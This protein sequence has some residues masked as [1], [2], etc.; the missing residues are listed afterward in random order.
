[1]KTIIHLLVACALALSATAASAQVV[2]HSR[3]TGLDITGLE[4]GLEGSTVATRGDVLRWLFVAHE[5]IGLSELRPAANAQIR[6]VTSMAPTDAGLEVTTDAFGRAALEL[7]IPADAPANFMVSLEMNGREHVRRRFDLGVTTVAPQNL[8]VTM[9]RASVP[10]GGTLRAWGRL[11]HAVTSRPYANSEIELEWRNATGAP[12]AAPVHLRTDGAGVFTSSIRAPRSLRG[13]VSVSAH[14]VGV[15]NA[16]IRASAQAEVVEATTNAQLLIALSP[17]TLVV[18][19]RN[20][21]RIVAIVRSAEGRPIRN[22]IV[23]GNWREPGDVAARARTDMFGRAELPFHSPDI[24]GAFSDA[25]LQV[26]A[27]KPGFAPGQSAVVV[28]VAQASYA[29]SIAVEAGHLPEA[30]GGNVWIRVVNIDGSAAPAGVPV[31][32]TGPRLPENGVAGVTDASGIATVEINLLPHR[33]ENEDSCGGIAST[34]ISTH[35]GEGARVVRSDHCMP[36]DPDA[37]L[38]M[39]LGAAMATPAQHIRID[40]ARA[41]S[42]RGMPVV[43]TAS[44]QSSANAGSGMRALA[45]VIVPGSASVGELALPA[46]AVGLVLVR[47]RALIGNERVEVRGGMAALWVT[48]AARV[49]AQTSLDTARGQIT[50]GFTGATEADRSVYA[51]ALPIDEARSLYSTQLA[52]LASFGMLSDSRMDVGRAEDSFLRGA[53]AS[54]VPLDVDA[55]ALLRGGVVIPVPAPANPQALGHLRDPWRARAR[56]VGG[57]LALLFHAIESV[58]ANAVPGNIENVALN[59]PRGWEFNERIMDAVDADAELGDG[60]ATALGGDT[61]DIDA[62]RRMDSSFTYD[63]VARRITRVRL[64][65]LLRDLRTFVQEHQLDLRWG[66]RGD[67]TEWLRQATE[68]PSKL[69]DA[70]GR[71]FALR[72][73]PGGRARFSLLVPVS[74]YELVSSGPNGRFG[75]ADDVWDPTGRVLSDTSLYGSAVGESALVAR[76]RGVEL[77]RA[78]VSMMQEAFDGDLIVEGGD[79]EEEDDTDTSNQADWDALPSIVRLDANALALRRPAR[80]GDGAETRLTR[81][82]STG[83]ALNLTLDEEPRTWGVVTIATTNDGFVDI[84]QTEARGGS[85]LLIEEG[86]P[87]RLRTNEPV[88]L[89]VHITNVGASTV[90]FTTSAFRDAHVSVSAVDGVTLRPSESGI[91]NLQLEG[92]APGES[93]VSTVFN[94]AGRPARTL[95]GHARV[96]RGLHPIRRRATGVA[97][98]SPFHAE[99]SIP[100]DAVDPVARVVVATPAG[101]ADDPEFDEAQRNDPAL[102]AWSYAL[103]GR[104]LPQLLRANLLRAQQPDGSFAGRD[105]YLATLCAVVALS[106]ADVSDVDAHAASARARNYLMQ[107]GLVQSRRGGGAPSAALATP[108]ALLALAMGGSADPFDDNE[109]SRDPVQAGV[110]SIRTQLRSVLREQSTNPVSLALAA[111]ALLLVQPADH[112]ALAMY[113]IAKTHVREDVGGL[114]VEPIETDNDPAR[115]FASTL[116]LALAAHTVGDDAFASRLLGGAFAHQAEIARLS[117][118]PLLWLLATSS[119]GALGTDAPTH[120]FVRINGA[121]TPLVFDHGRAV[122]DIASVGPDSDFDIQVSREDGSFLV[123]RVEASFGTRFTARDG[124]AVSLSLAGDV[125]HV[126]TR[127]AMELTVTPHGIT[128]D[129]VVD[130]SLPVGAEADEVALS[131]LR[132]TGNGV[133]NVEAREPGFVR[134]T[135]R[136]LAV[137]APVV[138]PLPVAWRLAGTVRGFGTVAYPEADPARMTVLAPRELNLTVVDSE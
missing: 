52:N 33:D 117:G 121:V 11:S 97:L 50:V 34:Q 85:D 53:L 35:I 130:V 112:H 25:Q 87:T 43:V 95:R 96:D 24:S 28:R 137:D 6:V 57:R 40:L 88:T 120:A 17:T 111:S 32:V 100:S 83:G 26:T 109:S 18:A 65:G 64:F 45:S 2:A 15:R 94:V 29:A 47:A 76:L 59:G 69:A 132:R 116:A 104:T 22:A 49:R 10:V 93:D 23:E 124:G 5:V 44:V 60:G 106:A 134:I 107:S 20:A 82:G 91:V 37:T 38:R 30:L 9:M 8:T 123:A 89:P 19:P 48:P 131:V 118:A 68:E 56:F 54:V 21:M 90:T 138:L 7:P 86:L 74:G 4:L 128:H 46:D 31:R 101:L 102:F 99:L 126:G 14:L 12:L 110:A 66:V 129:V 136:G 70:W 42:V 80:P 113:A 55:P 41:P 125:G 135:L 98:G 1:M 119:Y 133:V 36:I 63:N 51:V 81:L 115:V 27:S 77:G 73:A 71:P 105:T 3:P 62:L 78:T 67:P 108:D 13:T 103:Q 92:L 114:V 127:S 84:A 75:D 39:R 72:P 122:V 58:V 16:D 79:G 61:L